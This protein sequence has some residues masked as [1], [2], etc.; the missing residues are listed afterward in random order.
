[1]T[2]ESRA[3]V[4]ALPHYFCAQRVYFF[5]THPLYVCRFSWLVCK[6]T[7]ASDKVRTTTIWQKTLKCSRRNIL[8]TTSV[9]FWA[10]NESKWF[11]KSTKYN[12]LL[13]WHV[14]DMSASCVLWNGG[15]RGRVE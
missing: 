11:N 15:H 7:K 1:M 5:T 10:G 9:F 4:K 3:L 13:T 2:P 6:E 12:S 14:T 8:N